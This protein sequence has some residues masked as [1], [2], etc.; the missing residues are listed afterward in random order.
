MS[1]NKCARC[2]Q[3]FSYE[4]NGDELWV[5][6]LVKFLEIMRLHSLLRIVKKVKIIIK[7]KHLDENNLCEIYEKRPK[8]CRDFLCKKARIAGPCSP[9][10]FGVT[11]GQGQF[12]RGF[13][14]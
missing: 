10:S 7:C 3:E 14:N 13:Y 9:F 5:Q 12:E 11:G 6:K 1:C 4:L 2:C 8:R